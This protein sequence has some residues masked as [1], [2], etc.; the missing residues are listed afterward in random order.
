MDLKEMMMTKKLV[1]IKSEEKYI[2]STDVQRNFSGVYSASSLNVVRK[3]QKN[4]S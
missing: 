3:D 4:V 2:H 1:R